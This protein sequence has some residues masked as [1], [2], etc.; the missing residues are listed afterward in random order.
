M[1]AGTDVK[2]ESGKNVFTI[3]IELVLNYFAA[4]EAHPEIFYPVIFY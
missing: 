1:Q 4:D 3:I 2:K